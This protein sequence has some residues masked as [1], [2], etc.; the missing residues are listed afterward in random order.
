MPMHLARA[1]WYRNQR[2]NVAPAGFQQKNGCGGFPAETVRQN[3]ARRAPANYNEVENVPSHRVLCAVFPI[4]RID[5]L[6]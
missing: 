6:V 5:G 2:V 1:E 3:T 4:E